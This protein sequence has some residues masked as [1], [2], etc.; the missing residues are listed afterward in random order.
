MFEASQHGEFD[1]R[2]GPVF[3][4]LGPIRVTSH[5]AELD[6]RVTDLAALA[7]AAQRLGLEFRWGQQTYRWFGHYVGDTPLPEGQTLDTLG[8]CIH[9]IGV[10]GNAEA[11]EVGIIAKPDCS[12][13]LAFDYWNGGYGLEELAGPE[14]KKLTDEYAM[15]VAERAAT[16]QGWLFER[17]GD[18]SLLIHHPTGG[19]LTVAPGGTLEAN[20]FIGEGC[21]SAMLELGLPLNGMTAKA[22]NG[23][24]QAQTLVARNS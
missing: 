2:F 11:Y 6:I 10:P 7:D 23:Q 17:Q 13:A 15:V 3:M 19:T 18:G 14:C 8:K 1:C 16:M 12:Y 22:E 4:R 21:H 5:V 20:G 24:V 9:A